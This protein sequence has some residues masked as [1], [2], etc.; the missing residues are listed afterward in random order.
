MAQIVVGKVDIF[1]IKVISNNIKLK[2]PRDEDRWLILEFVR[3]GYCKEDLLRLNWFRIFQQ[4]LFLSDILG[5][6]G[7]SIDLQC[8]KCGPRHEKWSSFR[9]LKE[10][11]P[12]KDF[13]LWNKA[14]RQI[15]P[16][17]GI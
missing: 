17:G 5:A 1:D 3:I 14:L 10:A 15:V 6:G 8:F 7:K 13:K 4:V 2:M 9:F 16:A 12:R 11:H